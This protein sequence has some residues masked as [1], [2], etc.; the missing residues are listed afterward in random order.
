MAMLIGGIMGYIIGSLQVS[1]LRRELYSIW[2]RTDG[3]TEGVTIRLNHLVG[4]LPEEFLH[5]GNGGKIILNYVHSLRSTL[6]S[7]RSKLN[8]D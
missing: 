6:A 4:R 2:A 8:D 1:K 5:G 7:M 3:I